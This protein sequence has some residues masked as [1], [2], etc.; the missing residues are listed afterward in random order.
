MK[1]I[2]ECIYARSKEEE[3]PMVDEFYVEAQMYLNNKASAVPNSEPSMPLAAPNNNGTHVV[4]DYP[5]AVRR[6]SPRS[7]PIRAGVDE[8][9]PSPTNGVINYVEK[10][11]PIIKLLAHVRKVGMDIIFP[12]I[13]HDKVNM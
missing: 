4:A 1:N 11:E 3:F 8:Y 6:A 2:L 10:T 13:T 12:Q 5:A 7:A 9:I